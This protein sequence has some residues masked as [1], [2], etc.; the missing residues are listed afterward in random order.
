MPLLQRL[1]GAGEMLTEDPLVK[2]GLGEAAGALH[3]PVPLVI[4]LA[5][6][7]SGRWFARDHRHR[8]EVSENL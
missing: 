1:G 6:T 7:A 8:V 4:G 2:R 3:C 5:V